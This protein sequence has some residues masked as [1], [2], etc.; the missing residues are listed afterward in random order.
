MLDP[1]QFCIFNLKLKQRAIVGIRHRHWDESDSKTL[2]RSLGILSHDLCIYI[3]R[4]VTESHSAC[5]DLSNGH[6]H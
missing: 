2:A 3:V 4:R 1:Q 5:F 6:T